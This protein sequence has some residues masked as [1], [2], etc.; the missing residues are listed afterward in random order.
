DCRMRCSLAHA[1][2]GSAN[3]ESLN[4]RARACAWII[5]ERTSKQKI[6]SAASIRLMS[7]LPEQPERLVE[8]LRELIA[9]S[10]KEGNHSEAA[11]ANDPTKLLDAQ[12]VNG[13]GHTSRARG[14][15][16]RLESG[17]A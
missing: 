12:C 14:R 9:L 5:T 11:R 2:N 8:I 16:A 1:R 13:I 4:P 15:E 6:A 17:D 10:K 7:A 3:R